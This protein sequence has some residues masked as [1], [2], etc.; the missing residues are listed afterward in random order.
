M[1]F[2]LL[3]VGDVVRMR[4]EKDTDHIRQAT[5]LFF[6]SI[7]KEAAELRFYLTGAEGDDGRKQSVPHLNLALIFDCAVISHCA[8][9][10]S[11]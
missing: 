5:I 7:D 3:E 11:M 9:T 10:F 4:R 8:D 6:C 1:G 2:L